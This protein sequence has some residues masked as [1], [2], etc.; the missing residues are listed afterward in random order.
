MNE[1]RIG[2]RKVASRVLV[3]KLD[4]RKQPGRP[5]RGWENNI[6]MDVQWLVWEGV[7]LIFLRIGRNGTIL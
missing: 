3:G 6:E 4:R 5:R 7:D 2:D 1:A